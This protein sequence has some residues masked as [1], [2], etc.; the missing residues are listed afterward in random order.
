[1]TQYDFIEA[2]ESELQLRAIPF[3]R[4]SLLDFVESAWPL[5]EENSDVAFWANEFLEASAEP[6]LG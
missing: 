3:D 5:I 1:M 2:L 4:A 6:V